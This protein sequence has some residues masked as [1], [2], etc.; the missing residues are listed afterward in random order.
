MLP[1]YGILDLEKSSV[2]LNQIALG[3]DSELYF[4]YGLVI[5]C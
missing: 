2:M 1:F 5:T 3:S 4:L